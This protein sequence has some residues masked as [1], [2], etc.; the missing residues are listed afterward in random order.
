MTISLAKFKQLWEKR[1]VRIALVGLAALLLLLA[2]FC[3]FFRTDKTSAG[4]TPTE[5]EARLIVL[6][7][8]LDGVEDAT[9]M[10]TEEEGAAVGAV[11][12]YAGEGGFL[13][14]LHVLEI[15]SKALCLEK[16]AVAVYPET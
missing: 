6:L 3:I 9:V 7:K 5:R 10:I 1:S 15:A 8:Q 4:Y 2:V 11:V 14:R 13:T 16:N 12:I